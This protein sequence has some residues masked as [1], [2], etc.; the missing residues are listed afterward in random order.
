MH[1]WN[2][3]M[4]GDAAP[5]PGFG[6]AAER[7]CPRA[8]PM[9]GRRRNS[10]EANLWLRSIRTP[11]GAPNFLKALPTIPALSSSM[12]VRKNCAGVASCHQRSTLQARQEHSSLSLGSRSFRSVISALH[13][14]LLRDADLPDD[15]I[16][17]IDRRSGSRKSAITRLT[18]NGH[19]VNC[20]DSLS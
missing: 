19:Q 4:S 17:S 12:T 10:R 7:R 20:K 1:P 18:P 11:L 5:S 14:M 15:R 8:G 2:S 13:Q 6:S 9:N 16:Y 3:M